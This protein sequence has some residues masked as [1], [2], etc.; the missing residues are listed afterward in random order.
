MTVE[1]PA[2]RKRQRGPNDPDRPRRIA[3]SAITVIAEQGIEAL[4]HRKVAAA[5]GV[6]LGST[7]YYFG[8]LDDLVAAAL[9][10]AADRSVT[11]LRAWDASLPAD[12]DLAEALADF[13]VSSITEQREHTIAEYNLYA[14]ALHRPNLRKAAAD[15]DDALAEV[16]IARTDQTTGK[17]IATLTCGVLMQAVLTE[18]GPPRPDLVALFRRALAGAP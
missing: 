3:R 11:Q 6:P 16:F 18:Q 4:T 2:A 14:V 1:Q 8:S 5:A 7:T 12:V 10:E 9:A 13:V 15:W 17:L